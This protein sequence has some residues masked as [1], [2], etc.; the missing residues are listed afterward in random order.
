MKAD[1]SPYAI[2]EFASTRSGATF[3][4]QHGRDLAWGVGQEY[5]AR[6]YSDFLLMVSDAVRSSNPPNGM[7]RD[8]YEESAS[9]AADSMNHRGEIARRVSRQNMSTISEVLLCR[10]VDNF[11]C[12]AADLLREIMSAVPE[13]ATN[14]EMKIT[15]REVFECGDLASLQDLII[16][17]KV[18]RLS[19]DGFGNLEEYFR[20]Q[21]AFE[22]IEADSDRSTVT[23]AVAL[24]NSIVHRRGLVDER[25][26]SA[27]G[28]GFG[29]VGERLSVG[30]QTWKVIIPAIIRCV[31]DSDLRASEKFDLLGA[32][33]ERDDDVPRLQK[34]FFDELTQRVL[35]W[36]DP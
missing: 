24:R 10:Y 5:V 14:S 19:F 26:V 23:L 28:V 9:L 1:D 18:S 7:S 11:L 33:V 21:F 20:K 3:F 6:G 34:A 2:P 17:R 22:L 8:R 16:E 4:A 31:A 15:V 30:E 29:A 27:I 35:G 13:C 36:R 32:G 12:Y 25:L